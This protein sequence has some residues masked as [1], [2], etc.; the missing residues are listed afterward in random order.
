MCLALGVDSAKIITVPALMS[1]CFSYERHQIKSH[2]LDEC[3]SN[4]SFEVT[5]VIPQPNRHC[6]LLTWDGRARK[7]RSHLVE[8]PFEAALLGPCGSLWAQSLATG[9]HTCPISSAPIA[10]F[11][12]LFGLRITGTLRLTKTLSVGEPRPEPS[13][14]NAQCWSK[15]V[16]E[17]PWGRKWC[18]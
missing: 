6:P 1:L 10:V 18:S 3:H 5:P 13:T 12:W 17:G 14:G 7:A 16:E 8:G 2:T 9:H 4:V 15:E 11:L